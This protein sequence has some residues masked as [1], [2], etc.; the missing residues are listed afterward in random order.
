MIDLHNLFNFN[1]DIHKTNLELNSV[2]KHYLHI[3]RINTTSYGNKSLRYYCAILWNNTFKH[4]IALDEIS[5][6]NKTLNQIFSTSHFKNIL[7]KHF[8][9]SY[10]LS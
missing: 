4:G 7:K 5:K 10:S 1:C 6:H 8:L 2:R 3:P 9:F